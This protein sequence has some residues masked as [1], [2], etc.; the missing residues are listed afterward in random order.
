MVKIDKR[1]LV[2]LHRLMRE[3]ANELDIDSE[4]YENLAV[5]PTDLHRSKDAHKEAVFTLGERVTEEVEKTP[6]AAD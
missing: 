4:D 2:Y 5:S 3:C 1:T 6:L